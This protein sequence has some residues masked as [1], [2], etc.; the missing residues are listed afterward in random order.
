MTMSDPK[1]YTAIG[2]MSGTSLDGVDAAI[3]T[4]DGHN[5]IQFGQ[6]TF[7]PYPQALAN[8]IKNMMLAPFTLQHYLQI[9]QEYTLLN[10]T[11]C[12]TLINRP[13]LKPAFGSEMIGDLATQNHSIFDIHE[14]SNTESTQQ[15]AAEAECRKRANE[16]KH[17]IDV[18]GFHGQ[19]LLHTPQKGI[20]HQ[21]GN[22]HL[23]A[24]KLQ[25]YVIN[26]FRN[27]DIMHGGCGAPLVP[28]FHRALTTQ[29]TK[30]IAVLNIGGVSNITY[31]DHDTL[32]GFDIGI[33][34]A[35]LNDIM[36]KYH[37]TLYDDGGI[38]ASQGK[39]CKQSVHILM[40]DNFFTQHHPK[41]LDRN[42]FDFK[43][44]DHLNTPDK[45]ATL[46]AFIVLSLQ[47]A[48]TQLPKLPKSIY[49]TGGGRKNTFLVQKIQTTLQLPVHNI[50][51]LSIDGD[52]LEAYA[53]G[54]L[55]V[56]SLL[57]LPLSY[58][59]TTGCDEPAGLLGGVLTKF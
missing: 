52:M 19:T 18:I 39:V 46:I 8:N 48:L 23:L 36:Q 37:N 13:L 53:F 2:L 14:D 38:I 29:L 1:L 15:F 51:I 6:T 44:L 5:H 10:I 24:H 34:N 59:S 25:C 22:A 43:I 50:D 27:N 54:Y 30:P 33:G 28:I 20:T 4:T 21:M 12:K 56:R 26:Q 3:V 45:L 9:E 31:I 11:A 57:A 7:I 17:N 42:H 35:P 41:A 32:I 55:A 16:H 40:S 49:I 47:K 58:P